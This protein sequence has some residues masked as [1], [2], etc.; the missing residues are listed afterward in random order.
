ME[1]ASRI[2]VYMD[3]Q[4][5]LCRWSR[6]RVE[7]FDRDAR[8][9]WL[10]L[11]E[12]EALR[13]AAPHTWAEMTEEMYVRRADGSWTKGYFGWLEVLKVLPRW[14]WLSRALSVW[15]FT[16]VGPIF[17][18]WLASRRYTLFGIPPPCDPSGACSIHQ[19]KH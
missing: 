17:Y 10:D 4:C 6:A 9:E 2:E 16:A 3:G 19:P 11:N 8:I 7:P 14:R 5:P 18:R 12:P 13:R 15:P 1:Q